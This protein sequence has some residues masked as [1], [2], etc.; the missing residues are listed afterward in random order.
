MNWSFFR[1]EP[2]K[3]FLHCDSALYGNFRIWKE[4]EEGIHDQVHSV[5]LVQYIILAFLGGIATGLYFWIA[6]YSV[7]LLVGMV[8]CSS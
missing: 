4:E 5:T 8:Y 3:F 6:S 7:Q 2:N 1:V